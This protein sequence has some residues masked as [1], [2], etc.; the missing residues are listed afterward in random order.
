MN[1]YELTLIVEDEQQKRLEQVAKRFK[2]FSVWN[3][4]DLLQFSINAVNSTEF[5]LQFLERKVTQMEN[6][7]SLS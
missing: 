7:K 6:D 4:K 2:K 3:E 1:F 5:L